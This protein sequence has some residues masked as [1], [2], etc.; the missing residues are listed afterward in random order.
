MNRFTFIVLAVCMYSLGIA[1]NESSTAGPKKTT[2]EVPFVGCNSDGQNGPVDAPMGKSKPISIPPEAGSQLAYYKSEQISVLAPRSWYCF[3]TYG[4]N[5]VALY[6]SAQPIDQRDLLSAQWKGLS[7]AVVEVAYQSGD[8]S[9]RFTVARAIARVFPAHKEFA[10]RV[11]A[12]DVG[13]ETSF[14]FGPYSTDKLTYKSTEIVE[15]QTPGNKDGLGTDFSRF[16]KNSD[17]ITGVAILTGEPPDLLF[18]AVRLPSNLSNLSAV[19][20][21]ETERTAGN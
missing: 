21:Q 19:I 7:G 2:A 20:V 10:K 13:P 6:V 9:G 3:G 4:S 14:R 12:E 15:F 1:Q 16:R 8:T 18:L 11:S 5:G 17:P